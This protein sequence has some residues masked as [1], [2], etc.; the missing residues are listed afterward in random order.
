M[1]IFRRNEARNIITLRQVKL[2]DLVNVVSLV[3]L[4]V[5][6]KKTSPTPMQYFT[7]ICVAGLKLLGKLLRECCL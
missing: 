7:S 1:M 2:F 4:K 5:L 6:K 3:K